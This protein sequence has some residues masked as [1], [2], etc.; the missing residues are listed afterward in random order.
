MKQGLLTMSQKEV[1]R[2]KVL[3]FVINRELTGKEADEILGLCQK[4]TY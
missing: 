1:K 4:Q 3:E 2:I